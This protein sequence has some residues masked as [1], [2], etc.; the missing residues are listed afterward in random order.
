MDPDKGDWDK[1]NLKPE[2]RQ[3]R[4]DA[5]GS[6][7]ADEYLRS[8]TPGRKTESISDFRSS[9]DHDREVDDL[10]SL[11]GVTTHQGRLAPR[12][13]N[14]SDVVHAAHDATRAYDE[15]GLGLN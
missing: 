12:P 7:L 11:P 8:L 6:D 9:R 2:A 13:G 3:P 4:I 10:S 1:G 15:N 5:R 14:G